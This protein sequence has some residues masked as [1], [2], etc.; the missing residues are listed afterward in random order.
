MA[1]S[2][3]RATSRLGLATMRGAELAPTRTSLG[4]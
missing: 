3:M 4:I 1:P 2:A